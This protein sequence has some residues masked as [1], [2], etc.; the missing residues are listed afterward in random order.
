MKRYVKRG[1]VWQPGASLSWAISRRPK[2]LWELAACAA[3]AL[4]ALRSVRNTP[5]FGIVALALTP[6]HL[7]DAWRQKNHL[8]RW[9]DWFRRPLAQK[10]LLVLLGASSLGILF[11][12]FTLHKEHPLT[13]EAPRAQYPTAAIQFM[14]EHELRGNLLVFFD[15]GDL[16]IFAL[17]DCAPS[18][19]GRL[20]ACYTRP[21]VTAHWH[22]YNAEPVDEN[23]LNL[24][25]ADLAL[26][27]SK[28]AGALALARRPDWKPV[29]FDDL[30]AVLVRGNVDRFPQLRSLEL[31]VQGSKAAIVGRATFPDASAASIPRAPS[32]CY[33]MDQFTS[34]PRP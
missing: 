18:I 7:A 15:W 10:T 21:L 1:S 23:I 22:L 28:L 20:D 29:Y 31:P 16:A 17:P 5:L 11:A 33:A 30:A 3:F 14:R 32:F 9:E 2:A 34:S 13:M 8:A 4:L 24:T 26:L 25:N 6:R 27:P 19:D 12:A